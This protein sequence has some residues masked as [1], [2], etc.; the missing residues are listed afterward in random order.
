MSRA[1]VKDLLMASSG[2]WVL[3]KQLVAMYGVETAFFLTSLAEAETYVTKGEGGW[4][5][6][7][8]ETVENLTG[9]TRYKQDRALKELVD[10]GVVETDVRGMPAKR[11]MKLNY[12]RLHDKFVKLPQTSLRDTNKQ[13]CKKTT[14]K[15]AENLQTSLRVSYNNKELNKELKDKE[16]NNKDILSGKPDCIPYAEIV[17]YLNEKANRQFKSTTKKTQSL[18]KARLN[19]GWEVEDFK[20]VIDK[21]TQ[22]WMG[23]GK[24]E[25]YLR[26]ETLFG[27][28]F[29]SYLNQNMKVVDKEQGGSYAGIEF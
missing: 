8:I 9:L 20:T 10:D 7:T 6:Q 3:N 15:D 18:I 25:N 5:Y 28:K 26:P 13:D 19:E 27:T 11:Y 2:Y 29:E 1:L 12:K 4:F 16:L 17:D 23:D 21:K 14:S 24:M 22:E